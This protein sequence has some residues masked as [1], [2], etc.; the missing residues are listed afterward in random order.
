MKTKRHQCPTCVDLKERGEWR[1]CHTRHVNNSHS[2][3]LSVNTT[4]G[5]ITIKAKNRQHAFG[6]LKSLNRCN[7]DGHIVS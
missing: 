6:L 7:W 2:Y 3:E 5:R 4:E 1:L